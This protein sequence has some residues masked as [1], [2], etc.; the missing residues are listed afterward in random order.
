MVSKINSN[1]APV[2]FQTMDAKHLQIISD[3]L[4]I[5]Y[6]KIQNTTELLAEGAT[7]PFIARYRKEATG[8]LDEVQLTEIKTQIQK[9]EE[10]EKRRLSI[11]KSIE[12]QGKLTDEL[13]QK[14]LS[15]Y[16]LTELEDVYLPYKKK[17]KTRASVAKEKGL[18]P[19]AKAIFEQR[20][21]NAESLASNFLTDKVS[22]TDEAL[23][24]AR[25]I[26]A[27]W[28]NEDEKARNKVRFSFRR[29]ATIRSKVARGKETDGAKYSDYFD[30]EE[31]LKKCP[32]HR[33]LAIRR[34][35]EEGFLRVS[36]APD[37]E[38]TIYHL[39]KLI[40]KGHGKSTEQVKEAIADCYKRLLSSS[41]E[42]EFRNL[43]K[44]KADNE[45]IEVFVENLKQLLLS[46]PLG[47]KRIL[48]IDPG[49]RTGCKL[50]CLDQDGSFLHHSTIFPHPPQSLE[51]EAIQKLETLADRYKIEALAIGNG[52]A[53]RETLAIC[54][55]CNFDNP[56]ELFIVNESGASIYSASEIAREEFPDLDLTV[57]GAI[58]IGRRLMDPLAELVKIDPKSIGVGQYQHDVNQNQLKQSLDRVVES[59]VNSVGINLNTAS[60]HLLTYVSGLGPMLAQNIVNYRSENGLF[61]T[62]ADLKQVTRM[63]EKAFEQCAGFLRIRHAKNLLDNT[64][65][66]PEAYHIVRQMASDLNASVEDLIK[67][68]ALRKQIRVENYITENIG[69]PTLKDIL[70]EL[71]K[72]GLDPRGEVKAFEFANISSIDD[73][74]EGMVLPGIINN[75]TNFGAFVDIGIKESGLVHISQLSNTFVKSPADVVSLQQEVRVKV[76]EIDKAR[77]RVSLSMKQV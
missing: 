14:I 2:Q 39:E 23:Q 40:L 71:E 25:D 66:H 9:L 16:N 8:S 19:L 42:T 77:K 30:F 73:L 4:S 18:E 1:F 46:P 65:V 35:E 7:I 52:T 67:N 76:L 45:A 64:A 74:Q 38:E 27:E 44:E 17:R 53:G 49:F 5:S 51:Y 56:V 11:L 15:I 41:I 54:K 37:E 47:Q 31:P 21:Q 32:S 6:K 33:L 20:N 12:E 55:K 26:I 60:K 59:C 3:Q 62:R 10:L 75:I 48:A 69:L 28:I 63:G 29:N 57:R 72:P 50:I 36:I 24:G 68:A 22:T 70:E 13:R 58:S 43:A 34:G 61:Q